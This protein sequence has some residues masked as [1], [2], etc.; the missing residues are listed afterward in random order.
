MTEHAERYVETLASD[1]DT[2]LSDFFPRKKWQSRVQYDH[3]AHRFFLDV[4]V[5]DS[6][7]AG[8]ERFVSLVAFYGRGQRR[9][10]QERAG[11]DLQCRL[12][13]NDGADLTPRLRSAED[14]YLA[15]GRGSEIGRRLAWLGFRQR[16]VR[17]LI[18]RSLLWG[19]AIVFLVAGLG[20]SVSEA[21]LLCCAALLVQAVLSF[22]LAR[23][24][25]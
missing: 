15:E 21:V 10:L 14:S 25:R 17:H 6:G 5:R 20:F 7:L 24:G 16:V 9:A 12:F 3:V 1:L 13:S 11:L 8:D 18:P 23:S 19:A 22:A 2:F 4:I